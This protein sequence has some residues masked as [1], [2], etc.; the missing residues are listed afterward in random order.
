V[1]SAKA[2]RVLDLTGVTCPLT[3][4]KT[5]VA[6]AEMTTGQVLEVILDPGEPAETVPR[7][8]RLNDHEILR[9]SPTPS[10]G[11]RVRILAP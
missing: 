7:S 3:F 2:H 10:G 1:S 8:L 11:L 6:L 4:A 9:E 5:T